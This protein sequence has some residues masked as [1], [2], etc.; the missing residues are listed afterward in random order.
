MTSNNQEKLIS[1]VMPAYK[2]EKTVAEDLLNVKKVLESYSSMTYST[3]SQA[4]VAGV[5]VILIVVVTATN[6][7]QSIFWWEQTPRI[8]P[9]LFW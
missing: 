1:V 2:Q 3:R 6:R 8:L 4:V 7:P 9:D 5:D